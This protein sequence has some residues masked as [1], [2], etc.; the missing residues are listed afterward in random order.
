V[1]REHWHEREFWAWWW[2]TRAAWRLAHAAGAAASFVVLAGV[3]VFVAIR[4]S[5]AESSTTKTIL[6][7]TIT[8]E[9]SGTGDPANAPPHIRTVVRYVTSKRVVTKPTPVTRTVVEPRTLTHATSSVVT[10][11]VTRFRLR[12]LTRTVAHLV[13]V[14]TPP[15]TATQTLPA[16]TVFVTVT[17]KHGH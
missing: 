9:Q 3:G 2:Q 5:S 4:V 8:V 7:Q 6:W 12:R 14:T 1:F 15:V 10:R 16:E 13:T 11:T 17:V